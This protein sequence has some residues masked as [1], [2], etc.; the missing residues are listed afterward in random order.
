MTRRQDCSARLARVKKFGWLWMFGV[1]DGSTWQA[2]VKKFGWL[3]MFVHWMF[4][5]S[6]MVLD[7]VVEH[8]GR[9]CGDGT[10]LRNE[11]R[12]IPARR[13]EHG[14]GRRAIIVRGVGSAPHH[15]STTLESATEVAFTL[16]QHTA[17]FR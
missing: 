1:V 8:L 16:N 17:M 3:W 15:H 2:R 5:A 6:W 13:R 7:G 14:D 9:V 10:G 4:V 11:R 12:P